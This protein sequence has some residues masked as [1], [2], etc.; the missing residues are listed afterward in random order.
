MHPRRLIVFGFAAIALSLVVTP[1]PAQDA[2]EPAA[3][4]EISLDADGD[5]LIDAG[6]AER[7]A[8]KKRPGAP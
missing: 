1:V 2:A 5:G 8:G 4:A 6:E 3:T 7:E